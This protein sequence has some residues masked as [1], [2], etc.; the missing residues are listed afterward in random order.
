MPEQKAAAAHVAAA[1]EGRREVERPAKGSNKYVDV[2]SRGDAAE[3]HDTGVGRKLRRQRAQIPLERLAIPHVVRGDV[4]AGELSNEIGGHDGIRRLQ[5]TRR[6]DDE[7]RL[8]SKSAS[9]G[10]FA[11]KVEAAAEAER[12]A[13]RQASSPQSLGDRER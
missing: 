7:R 4:D 3:K 9:V 1:D 6:R 10:D 5:T 8:R 12:I 2:L 13:E 11:A